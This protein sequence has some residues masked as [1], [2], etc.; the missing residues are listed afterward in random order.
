MTRPSALIEGDLAFPDARLLGC[1][2]P[3]FGLLQR[4]ARS[5][6]QRELEREVQREPHHQMRDQPQQ[7]TEQPAQQA[8]TAAPQSLRKVVRHRKPVRQR[9]L[10]PDTLF[11]FFYKVRQPRDYSAQF[12]AQLAEASYYLDAGKARAHS[13][14]RD[15][16]LG[17]A[18]FVATGIALIWLL[19]TGR[20]HDAAKLAA[21]PDDV[22]SEQPLPRPRPALAVVQHTPLTEQPKPHAVRPVEPVAAPQAMNLANSKPLPPVTRVATRKL[23]SIHETAFKDGHVLSSR[24]RIES[25]KS[26]QAQASNVAATYRPAVAGVIASRAL[27]DANETYL[28]DRLA[29]SRATAPTVPSPQ[30][31]PLTQTGPSAHAI[32][33]DMTPEQAELINWAAQQ[34]RVQRAIAAAPIVKAQVSIPATQPDAS[35]NAHLTQRR[36]VDN[37][38]AFGTDPH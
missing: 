4:Q 8:S 10:P 26:R 11:R 9:P 6:P 22:H 16:V 37:P 28:N 18:I 3:P 12:K 13:S 33:A 27:S 7:E 23:N 17:A 1:L 21:M 5:N 19:T 35:W 15:Y 31:S 38:S 14:N 25:S 30:P 29:S 34:Q 2:P 20:S 36:I 32:P 24:A